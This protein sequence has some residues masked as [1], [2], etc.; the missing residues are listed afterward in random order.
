MAA[1]GW[2]W[3]RLYCMLHGH[4]ALTNCATYSSIMPNGLV[5]D[6]RY[7]LACDSPVWIVHPLEDVA[8][9]LPLEWRNPR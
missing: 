2:F 5:R 9:E 4:R 1:S 3:Q 6:L 8:P 7:C